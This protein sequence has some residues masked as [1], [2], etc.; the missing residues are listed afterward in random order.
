MVVPYIGTWIETYM[1]E[2]FNHKPT[3]RTLYRYVDWNANVNTV[4]I[5]G[6][7]VPYIGTWIETCLKTKEYETVR[8]VPYIGTWIETSEDVVISGLSMS[9]LI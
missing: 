3:G 4:K 9:Y 7:V 5:Q 2:E 6:F 8:V 1:E